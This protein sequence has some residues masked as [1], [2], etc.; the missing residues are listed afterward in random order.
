MRI[1]AFGDISSDYSGLERFFQATQDLSI[2]SYVCLGDILHHNSPRGKRETDKCIDI[3]KEHAANS[4]SGNHDRLLVDL[5]PDY[6][7]SETLAYLQSL[8]DEIIINEAL[9]VHKSPSRRWTLLMRQ[10]EFDYLQNQYPNLRIAFFGHT[11]K[12]LHFHKAEDGKYKS[13]YF[14]KINVNH[15]VS[16]G[17][18]L[19]NPGTI[20]GAKFPWGFNE[21]PSFVVYDTTS[22]TIGFHK[23]HKNGTQN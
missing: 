12:R 23:I 17:L 1:A 10:S 11:H 7:S 22:H 21:S 3:L 15:D 4:I 16:S 6:V 5:S 9:F 19:I 8:P 2:D 14:P 13:N 18:H 20:D